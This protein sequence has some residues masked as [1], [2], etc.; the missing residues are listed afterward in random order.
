MKG[1]YGLTARIADWM[2]LHFTGQ[3]YGIGRLQFV[4]QAFGDELVAYRHRD[5]TVRALAGDGLELRRDGLINGGAG[6]TETAGVWTSRLKVTDTEAVGHPIDPATGVVSDET[7]TL[8]LSEWHRVLRAGD[9]VLDVH[10]PETG[11]MTVEV[12]DE[13]IRRALEFYRRHFP[14]KPAPKAFVCECWMFDPH[15]AACLDGGSNILRFGRQFYLYPAVCDSWEAIR[16]IFPVEIPPGH[17]GA[18]DLSGLSRETSL[19][20]ALLD[21]VASGHRWR[22]AGGFVL[23]DDLPWGSEP[24]RNG[25]HEG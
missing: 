17:D 18:V 14:D 15:L 9:A 20:R 2:K 6:V 1:R 16:H 24:Y 19:Q 8:D 10:I 3:L 21:G 23:T 12:C 13:S 22:N 25:N 11:P 4:H 5:G 7:V